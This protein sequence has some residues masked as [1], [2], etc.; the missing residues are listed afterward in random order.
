MI[1]PRM[2]CS[3]SP[4]AT[5]PDA[6][7]IGIAMGEAE[8]DVIEVPPLGVGTNITLGGGNGITHTRTH[9]FKGDG[10]VSSVRRRRGFEERCNQGGQ[11][12]LVFERGDIAEHR[13]HPCQRQWSAV[14]QHAENVAFE[15][16]PT[17]RGRTAS[18]L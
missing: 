13:D 12:V 10:A 6:G 8:G 18:P 14:K 17:L 11:V 9:S 7:R 1:G 3:P 15:V 16:G 5:D 4:P 2:A